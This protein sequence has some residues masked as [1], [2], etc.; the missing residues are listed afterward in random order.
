MVVQH[1]NH[2]QSFSCI[3]AE[4][5]INNNSN[6]L[7]RY[8]GVAKFI[9]INRLKLVFLPIIPNSLISSNCKK[10]D[11]ESCLFFSAQK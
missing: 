3:F 10:T 9:S 8:D 11:K 6:Y 1:M 2:S 7:Y 5:V 4:A